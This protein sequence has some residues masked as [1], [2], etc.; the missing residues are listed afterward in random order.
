MKILLKFILLL[1]G[2]I[3]VF[4]C[5]KNEVPTKPPANV[6]PDTTS[7]DFTWQMDV[8]GDGEASNLRDVC[9]IDEND[10]WA[11]GE[12]YLKD[13]TG[14]LDPNSYN[15][16]KWNGKNWDLKRIPFIG[17]CSAV[18][19]PPIKA[20]WA[21]SDNNILLTNGGSM[22]NY[23][24]SNATLDCRM[25]PLLTGAINKIYAVNP[26]EV[27]AVGNNGSIVH[28]N[29]SGWQKLESGTN[30]D[31]QDIWGAKNP[32]TGEYTILAVASSIFTSYEKEILQIKGTHV[33][34][35]STLGIDWPV[36]AIWF[37]PGRIYYAVGVG[38]Y[39]RKAL[40]ATESWNG[41]G[42]TVTTYTS[43]AIRGNHLNDIFVVG[44]FGDVLHYNGKSWRSYRQATALAQGSYVSV[45]VK[46]DW[47]FAVGHNFDRA[48]VLRGKRMERQN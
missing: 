34:K 31:I 32:V 39:S 46:G 19:Y 9:I 48:V 23:N 8:L 37:D 16:S 38:I 22:V 25:N 17:S 30:Q 2:L 29:G 47:F 41:P 24:G 18:L 13:S 5:E 11:V 1:I 4:G 35:V 27:Y 21:F 3:L 12:I 15:A 40:N 33:E 20:I 36:D 42:L 14:Q 10:V 6:L 26:E 44:A 43:H 28:Y 7:H 45:S